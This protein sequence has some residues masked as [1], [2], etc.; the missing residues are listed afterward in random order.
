MK[1]FSSILILSFL[2]LLMLLC[3]SCGVNE[4]AAGGAAEITSE[5]TAVETKQPEV[6]EPEAKESVA[7]QAETEQPEQEQVEV[8]QPETEEPE[9]QQAKT[10]Q[11][12]QEQVEVQ[13]AE[14]EE[15]ETQQAEA[16]QP[17][18]KPA[19]V[20]E[21]P[22]KAPVVE[23]PAEPNVVAKI[24]DYVIER[25]ELDTRLMSELRPERY[26]YG[27]QSESVD[28]NTVLTK[29]IAEKAMVIEARKQDY[30][31]RE[32]IHTYIKRF[33]DKMLAN[34]L[35]QTNL[36]SKVV[37]TDS[38]IDKKLKSDPKL[39]RVRARALIQRE[40][41]NRLV[42]QYYNTL[43]KKFHVQKLSDNFQKAAQIHD[44]LLYRPKKPRKEGWIRGD[45]IREELTPE[46]KNLVLA[47]YD[48]GEVTLKD[49][50]DALFQ[51]SPP[52]RP[53]DLGSAKGVERL[54]DRVLRLPI[55]VAEAML[56]GLDKNE[57]LA[58]E[59]RKYEDRRL[60]G[61]MM[62]AKNK[63]VEEP[64]DEQ[65]VAY[66][67]KN[68]QAFA[69]PKSIK[70][71]QIWCEDLKTAQKARAE[72]DGGKNF[73][74]AKQTYSLQEG[75]KP[76]DTYP[77]GEGMFWEY[78]WKGDPNEIIGPLK[79][80]YGDGIKWRI[81]KI[82]EKKPGETKEY[83]DNVKNQAKWRLMDELRKAVMADYRKQLL[84]KYS[85]EIYAD[86]IK[87]IDPLNIP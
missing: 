62:S 58:E 7:E 61:E 33:K 22:A 50:F 40:K 37:V 68:K 28:A 26:S 3:Y 66:F 20:E 52:S 21:K 39:D 43:H 34:L 11:P 48:G 79:G 82:L 8:Q 47:K 36:G 5:P 14:T 31:Q 27:G 19:V 84:E 2:G 35:L 87:D 80:F 74:S 76:L 12:E 41:A 72:L 51:M 17:E 71:D 56:Q 9:T 23:A 29:M 63:E 65:I 10:E 16:E 4:P 15:P 30:L 25:K 49:W 64:T 69:T 70:V 60:L 6:Q 54:L 85:Y 83:S 18:T 75:G 55:F 46:E 44:R 78:L 86:R 1:V 13:Q 24:G 81:V 77:G 73:E 53:S 67:E 42:G 32:D 59:V 57:D 38:E 45:Q